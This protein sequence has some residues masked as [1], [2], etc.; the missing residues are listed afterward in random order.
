MPIDHGDLPLDG[1]ATWTA[2]AKN[3]QKKQAPL[4][5]LGQ[6]NQKSNRNAQLFGEIGKIKNMPIDHGG[7]ES[8][9]DH[10][11]NMTTKLFTRGLLD[12]KA[13][14]DNRMRATLFLEIL[15][16]QENLAILLNKL[17]YN[18]N[19]RLRQEASHSGNKRKVRMT[20]NPAPR[21][22]QKTC[23]NETNKPTTTT[24]TQA[25]K[26]YCFVARNTMF[27]DPNNCHSFNPKRGKFLPQ[28][29]EQCTR[30][31]QP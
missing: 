10:Q 1:A 13:S 21:K 3:T 14:V 4:Y 12:F 26:G 16:T 7:F 29:I 11:R 23:H 6:S 15:E 28:A 18:W 25:V 27:P 19:R 2:M 20:T 22:R 9:V 8:P 31:N 17:E 24:T 5:N 30:S